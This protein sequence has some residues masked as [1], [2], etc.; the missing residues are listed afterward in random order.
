MPQLRFMDPSTQSA[1]G[2]AG[3]CRVVA[4]VVCFSASLCA[5]LCVLCGKSP[6]FKRR[7]TQRF[8]AEAAEGLEGD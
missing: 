1:G 6:G 7:G 5:N 2:G 3:F 8:F 4:K